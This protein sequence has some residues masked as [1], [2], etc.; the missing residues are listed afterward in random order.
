MLT[1][2]KPSC[3]AQDVNSNCTGVTQASQRGDPKVTQ[4]LHKFHLQASLRRLTGD[5][6][7]IN[8]G[9]YVRV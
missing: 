1:M 5:T 3:N 7:V 4:E 2:K 8:M 9:D 6:A